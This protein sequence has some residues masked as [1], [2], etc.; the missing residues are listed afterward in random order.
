ML[1]LFHMPQIGY[2]ATARDLSDKQKFPY[3]MRVVPP[4]DRQVRVLVD[5]CLRF[6]WKYVSAVYTAGVTLHL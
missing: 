2:S 4:D 5:L 1:Q 6:G 3:F